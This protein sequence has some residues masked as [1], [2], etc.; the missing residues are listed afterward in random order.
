MAKIPEAGQRMFAN[1]FVCKRCKS[2]LKTSSQR[3][4]QKKV[5]CRRCG[6][7]AFRAIKR[8]K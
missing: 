2:K 5:S 1:I 6:S 4:L 7:K 3:V 8:G